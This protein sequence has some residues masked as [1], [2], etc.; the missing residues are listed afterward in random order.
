MANGRNGGRWA[1]AGFLYQI[2]GMLSMVAYVSQLVEDEG[3]A[4]VDSLL[5]LPNVGNFQAHHEWFEDAAFTED[6][7]CVLV[8]FKYS[9]TGR[10]INVAEAREIIT[11]LDE[12]VEAATG[13][14][15]HVTA[16]VLFTNRELTRRG[17]A[18]KQHWEAERQTRPYDLRYYRSAS[19]ESLV[20]KLRELGQ[21]YGL[22]PDEAKDGI[23]ALIGRVLRQT[24]DPFHTPL[25]GSD[26]T[27]CFVGSSDA[28]RL[29]A[30]QTSIVAQEQLDRSAAW[31]RIDQWDNTPVKRDVLTDVVE[32]VTEHALV[33]LYGDGG[34]GKSVV[35][36]QLLTG[37][38]EQ[39]GCCMMTLAEDID[40]LWVVNTVHEWRNLPVRQRPNDGFDEAIERLVIAN[41]SSDRQILWLALDGLK[42]RVG[43][44]QRSAIKGLVEEFLDRDDALREDGIVPP[45]T[46]IVSCRRREGIEELVT[47]EMP[48]Y[49]GAVPSC[50]IQI[51]EFSDSEVLEAARLSSPELHRRLQ[52]RLGSQPDLGESEHNPILMEDTSPYPQSSLI[53]E[54]VLDALYH[55]AMWQAYLDDNVDQV[56]AIDGDIS[57]ICEMARTFIEW[58]HWKLKRR[59]KMLR[60]LDFDTLIEILEAIAEGSDIA[61]IHGKAHWKELAGATNR[62][63]SPEADTL[64]RETRSVG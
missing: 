27:E 5:T 20:G 50:I 48:N 43:S 40:N 6:D 52:S 9:S 22:F 14:G 30:E 37:F 1:L 8:Q 10:K 11:K 55:P 58:F 31:I 33:G 39:G 32:A 45:A 17:E 53:D 41:D 23:D 16:C 59:K 19:I 12:S 64:T 21:Q 62:L 18:A 28:Q 38:L 36:W 29:T 13:Q 42:E 56:A 61:E 46:L 54:R 35:L 2:L 51:G 60:D 44:D 34:C 3:E 24:E 57:A 47:R 49:P 26:F 15:Y 63:N 25:D 4:N 7:E